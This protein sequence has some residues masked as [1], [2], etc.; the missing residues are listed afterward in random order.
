MRFERIIPATLVRMSTASVL[1]FCLHMIEVCVIVFAGFQPRDRPAATNVKCMFTC[2][3]EMLVAIQKW[4][5]FDISLVI[6]SGRF[7]KY[8]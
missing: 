5:C 1:T 6:K 2:I 7:S 4:K 3:S 8:L